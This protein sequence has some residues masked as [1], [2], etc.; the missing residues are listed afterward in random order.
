MGKLKE[1]LLRTVLQFPIHLFIFYMCNEWGVFT[2]QPIELLV[3][4]A[5]L[6]SL[7]FS[8]QYVWF[9]NSRVFAWLMSNALCEEENSVFEDELEVF[10]DRLIDE[11]M[12]K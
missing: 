4:T 2:K 10:R 6:I 5:V 8:V 1:I 11:R 9:K 7:L 12:D 3:Y